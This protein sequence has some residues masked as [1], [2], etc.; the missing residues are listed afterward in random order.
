MIARGRLVD[1][2]NVQSLKTKYSKGYRISLRCE[3][4]QLDEVTALI[5]Y[6]FVVENQNQILITVLEPDLQETLT[7]LLPLVN[8]CEMKV[9][10]NTLTDV[11]TTLQE[12]ADNA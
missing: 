6:P 10:Q 11:Y 1:Y 2:G 3:Y 12:G 8:Q 9:Y 5:S 4:G 7:S